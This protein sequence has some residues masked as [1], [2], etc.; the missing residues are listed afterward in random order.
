ME[1]NPVGRLLAAR[2]LDQRKK[3]DDRRKDW[4]EKNL[5]LGTESAKTLA[6]G[7]QLREEKVAI[8]AKNKAV[9]AAR[10]SFDDPSNLAFAV[11][12]TQ[13]ELNVQRR[14]AESRATNEAKKEWTDKTEAQKNAFMTANG[15]DLSSPTSS[16]DAQ[17]LLISQTKTKMT[18][19]F[20][21][22]D[23]NY[24]NTMDVARVAARDRYASQP[25]GRPKAGR[26]QINQK[27]FLTNYNPLSP[28]IE[29]GMD[30]LKGEQEAETLGNTLETN[31]EKF[32]LGDFVDRKGKVKQGTVAKAF[33]KM[34]KPGMQKLLDYHKARVVAGEENAD[35]EYGELLIAF[36][37]MAEKKKGGNANVADLY[38]SNN[39]AS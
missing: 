29:R 4:Q 20:N 17:N 22:N 13:K 8:A 39:L 19:K 12:E 26:G 23:P 32:A 30:L 15:I 37:Y 36:R 35:K 21:P 31:P 18:A 3:R 9:A 5:G 1:K 28:T 7:K 16:R 6:R 25:A 2:G 27:R 11:G 10:T 34:T 38:K 33:K 14:E 24:A